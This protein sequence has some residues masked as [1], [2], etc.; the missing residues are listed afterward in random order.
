MLHG[1]WEDLICHQTETTFTELVIGLQFKVG[2][3]TVFCY[4]SSKTWPHKDA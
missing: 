2:S 3:K 4:F 1:V